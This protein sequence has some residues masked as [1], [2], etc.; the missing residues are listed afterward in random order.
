MKT[1]VNFVNNSIYVNKDSRLYFD[2][3]MKVT[4]HIDALTKQLAMAKVPPLST[5]TFARLK[6]REPDLK[7]QRRAC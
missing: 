5:R 2:F 4:F 7:H 3:L 6:S 1:D